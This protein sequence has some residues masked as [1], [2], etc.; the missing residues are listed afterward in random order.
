MKLVLVS[1][2]YTEVR[3]KWKACAGGTDV[4][5]GKYSGNGIAVVS[6]F[7]GKVLPARLTTGGKDWPCNYSR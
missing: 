3:V 1:V 5:P 4:L 6:S 2:S 7:V